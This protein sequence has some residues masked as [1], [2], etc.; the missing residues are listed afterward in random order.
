MISEWLHQLCHLHHGL[1]T[2]SIISL[3]PNSLPGVA[4][5]AH[6]C[7]AL[8]TYFENNTSLT[9]LNSAV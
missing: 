7:I 5:L 8:L 4:T 2:L 6:P 3:S 1:Y 9:I